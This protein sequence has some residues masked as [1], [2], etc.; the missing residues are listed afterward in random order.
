MEISKE[1]KNLG[2]KVNRGLEDF[3]QL[4]LKKSMKSKIDGP[5][6]FH[7]AANALSRFGQGL[8]SGKVLLKFASE[9]GH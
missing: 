4:Y 1:F 3:I 8:Q 5:Y 6:P 2:L 9:P 7:E